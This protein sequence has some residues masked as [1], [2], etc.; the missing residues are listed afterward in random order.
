[1]IARNPN[2]IELFARFH[3]CNLLPLSTDTLVVRAF[4]FLAICFMERPQLVDQR[5]GRSISAVIV[6]QP[7]C[8]AQLFVI[9]ASKF[10]EVD[11]PWPVTDIFL[12]YARSFMESPAGVSYLQALY[13]LVTTQPKFKQHRFDMVRPIFSV[14]IRSP[15]DTVRQAALQAVCRTLNDDFK[16]PF[17]ALCRCL[18]HRTLFRVAL[19]VT[20]RLKAFPPSPTFCR[21]L[22]HRATKVPR[23]FWALCL[24]A[25]QNVEN[26]RI[27]L[28][29]AN[30]MDSALI[31][32]FRLVLVIFKYPE[33]RRLVI[34]TPKGP[35]F[36]ARMAAIGDSDVL[37][38]MAIMMRRCDVDQQ[39]LTL[40]ADAT[41][42]HRYYD[43]LRKCSHNPTRLAALAMLDQLTRVG[44]VDEFALYIPLLQSMLAL[45]NEVSGSVI[46][47][48]IAFS[49]HPEL[50]QKLKDSPLV[51]YFQ[52]LLRVAG[53]KQIAQLF[54]DNV[55]KA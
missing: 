34:R 55:S 38:G 47:L 36:L 19:S 29:I 3:F 2:F 40:L 17:D 50:A 11:D 53:F 33:L 7:V 25:D 15:I 44:Y 20:L 5:M 22:V 48:F 23:F 16:I 46:A 18:N 27:V 31:E 39:V 13:F 32:A 43:S 49:C 45:R 30:W 6:N 4:Q 21:A 28:E 51:P 35:K 24:F 8:A 14:F 42:F 1:M 37:T 54:L 41:F 10:S 12:S 26:A 9:Y 52:A